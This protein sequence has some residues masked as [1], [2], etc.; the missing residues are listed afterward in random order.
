MPRWLSNNKKL[1]KL[2]GSV[3]AQRLMGMEIRHG[4]LVFQHQGIYEEEDM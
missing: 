3:I 2:D 1:E 4:F